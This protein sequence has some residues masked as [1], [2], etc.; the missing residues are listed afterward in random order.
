MAPIAT[1]LGPYQPNMTDFL[2]SVQNIITYAKTS[3]V[4]YNG[5]V[6]T[7]IAFNTSQ[8]QMALN[9]DGSS[10]CLVWANTQPPINNHSPEQ[11]EG[12]TILR[13]ILEVVGLFVA[14]VAVVLH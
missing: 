7:V 3:A 13:D 1:S 9:L 12:F 2:P 14:A 8:C 11:S 6:E 4:V 5:L 10:Q